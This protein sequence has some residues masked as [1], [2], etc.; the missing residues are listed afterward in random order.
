[1]KFKLEVFSRYVAA[2][3][4]LTCKYIIIEIQKHLAS[5]Q[6]HEVGL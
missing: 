4:E 5:Y 1:M 6:S 2:G 3:R